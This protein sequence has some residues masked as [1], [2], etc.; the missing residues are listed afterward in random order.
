MKILER[1]FNYLYYW[2]YKTYSVFSYYIFFV[3]IN[4]LFK[5]I[6]FSEKRR[7]E[8]KKAYL[9]FNNNRENGS[10]ITFA[11][12]FIFLSLLLFYASLCLILTFCLNVNYVTIVYPLFFVVAATSY[13]TVYYALWYKKK[14]LKYFEEF[15]EKYKSRWHY[16]VV[17]VY[18]IGMFTF[19]I[20]TIK[21]T[22][23]FKLF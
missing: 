11:Y 1:Q 7:K 23:D 18:F 9:N 4:F 6:P 17:P 19:S 14:Y 20:L 21:Y 5:L 16:L 2:Q 10:S 22:W 13:V 3:P 15:D 8:A 12:S